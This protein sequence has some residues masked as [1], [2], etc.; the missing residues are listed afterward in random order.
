MQ[1]DNNTVNKKL[2]YALVMV[3]STFWGLSFLATAILVEYVDP[4][5]IQ[6]IRWLIAAVIFGVY[7]KYKKIRIDFHKKNVGY[8]I[9]TGLCEPCIYMLFETYGIMKTSA[10]I[11]SIFVA[12]IPCCVL[13]LNALIYHRHTG[14]TAAA[15]I[16]MAFTGVAFCTFFSPAFSAGGDPAGY[17]LLAGAVLTGGV[18]SI[19]AN[20]A[21]ESY[22]SVETTAVMAFMGTVH[23]NVLNFLMGYGTET[24]TVYF[25]D[26]KLLVGIVF[27]GVCCSALCYLAFNK[28]LAIIDP[29]IGNNM[30][31][32]M[33]T[34][35]GVTAGIFIAGDPGGWYTVVGL[36]LTLIGVYLSTRQIG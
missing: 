9:L 1:T 21:G 7:L 5:Q 31:A 24:Y 3:I 32:S 22:T 8:L 13:I 14:I 33:T 26:I 2:I 20:K 30:S 16:L 11:G 17:L 4:V 10:S 36:T 28:I 34:F 15:G 23:F 19:A 12:T 25:S 6:A 29:A 18:Y 35:V 27:L